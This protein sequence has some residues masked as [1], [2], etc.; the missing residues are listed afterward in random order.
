MIPIFERGRQGNRKRYRV[1]VG[2]RNGEGKF[3]LVV[4]RAKNEAAA[5]EAA[6]KQLK[7]Q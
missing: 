6:R 7:K 5:P 2:Y 3:G 4:C 1:Y